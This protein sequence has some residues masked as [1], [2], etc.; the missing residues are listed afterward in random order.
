M[1]SAS[2]VHRI[3]TSTGSGASLDVLLALDRN[4]QGATLEGLFT[5]EA[6]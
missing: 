6:T 5:H 4:G 3:A 2:S 1:T